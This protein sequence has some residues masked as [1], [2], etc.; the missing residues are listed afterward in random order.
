MTKTQHKLS[1]R[2]DIQSLRGIAIICVLLFHLP[3]TFFH[4]GFLG[5][6]I[7]FVISGFLIT[8]K[9]IQIFENVPNVSVVKKNF[10]EFA[11][12]R[13]RRLAP[14]FSVTILIFLPYFFCLA[15]PI[16]EMKC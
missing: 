11:I 5:V 12:N 15:M 8:P 2:N 6:D 9:I 10:K 13:V 3:N 14:A 1:F 7:F 16:S 4:Q